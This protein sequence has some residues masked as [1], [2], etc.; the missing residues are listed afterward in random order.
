MVTLLELDTGLLE[1]ALKP[2]GGALGVVGERGG[3]LKLVK[4]SN[5]L[6]EVRL[7]SD[8]DVGAP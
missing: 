5:Q 3:L 2:R 8:K 4:L 1:G 6:G 7:L